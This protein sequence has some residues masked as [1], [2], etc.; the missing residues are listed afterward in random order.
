MFTYETRK[1]RYGREDVFCFA[2]GVEI[3][4]IQPETHDGK[5]QKYSIS[6]LD[7]NGEM[8][9][10]LG[11]VSI[12]AEARKKISAWYSEKGRE[13]AASARKR[14]SSDVRRLP[15]FDDAEFY[16]TPSKLAGKMIALV[17]WK[18]V[19]SALEPSA[20]RGDLADAAISF[21]SSYRGSKK[22]MFN[23]RE[24]W[25]D[26]IELD[27]DLSHILRGK[28]YHVVG[29]DFLSF[30]SLKKYDLILMNPPFSNGDEHLLK[31]IS[32]MERGG[33][34]VCLLNAETIR[35]PYTNRRN[36]LAQKLAE[37]NAKIEFISG[38]FSHAARKTD[39]EIALV[40]LNIAPKIQHSDILESLKKSRV[41]AGTEKVEKEANAL[42]SGNWIENLIDGFDFEARIGQKM[43]EEYEALLPYLEKGM[44]QYSKPLLE[45]NIPSSGAPRINHFLHSL[46]AKYW[47]LLLE[48]PELTEKMTS[49]MQHEYLDKIRTL[50]D[51]DFDRYN[52]QTFVREI[53][54]QLTSG[55]EESIMDLF[56]SFSA[57]HS[58]YPECEKNVHYYNGWATNKAHKVGMKVIIPAN[59][60][61]ADSWRDEKLD[62]YRVVA[63]ISDLERAMNYLDRGET[64]FRSSASSAVKIANINDMNKA[65]FTWFDCTFY[66]K[67]TCHIK[68]NENARRII[69]R[70]NIFAAQKKN[71]LPPTYGKKHYA[72]MTAEEKAVIDDF[73]GEKEYEAILAD[74]SMLISSGDLAFS[75]LPAHS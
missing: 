2:D 56:E 41:P 38:A 27:S 66:K 67:G 9:G 10:Y 43:I 1:T 44:G 47:R 74:P 71:W 50:S 42:S 52:I 60:C 12:L 68:F 18:T 28:G 16:P 20:G 37:Y 22:A 26:C 63:L 29:D 14:R 24:N 73:Q 62:E 70:L 3:A 64:T 8:G 6:C 61:C 72:D 33:Q 32:L 31:A 57:K 49:A 75:A 46:R 25:I 19:Y 40:Y 58:W 30:H 15:A 59:G 48:R 13:S 21:A 65:R 51:F 54:H 45:L 55:I 17:D 5:I 39:V 11:R 7:A 34:I 4:C 35:N 69:D 36:L 53:A 23:E